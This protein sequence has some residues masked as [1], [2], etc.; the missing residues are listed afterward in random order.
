NEVKKKSVA[1]KNQK[2]PL[3]K[4]TL[5]GAIKLEIPE[6]KIKEFA[7]KNGYGNLD[8]FKIIHRANLINNSELEILYTYNAELR[9]IANYYKLANNYHH[10]DKLFHLAESS[11]IKT[12][13]NKRRST[14]MKVATSM[15]SHKQG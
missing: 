11:F 6:K 4:R 13:A 9:G 3:K 10:L 7:I 8:T 15:R 1:Y 14:S 5:S 12:I 2:H